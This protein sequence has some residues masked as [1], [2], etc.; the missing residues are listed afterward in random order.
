LNAA[1]YMVWLHTRERA[2]EEINR[3]TAERQ[4]QQKKAK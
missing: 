2:E 3:R 1:R 4:A